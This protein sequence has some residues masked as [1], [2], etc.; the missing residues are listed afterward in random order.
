MGCRPSVTALS[1][2]GIWPRSIAL[3]TSSKRMRRRSPKSVPVEADR[4]TLRRTESPS[5]SS[6]ALDSESTQPI[7]CARARAAAVLPVPGGP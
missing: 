6:D 1:K 4:P 5:R 3:S 7:S 2:A